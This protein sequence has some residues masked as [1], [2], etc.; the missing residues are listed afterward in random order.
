MTAEASADAARAAADAFARGE[1][2]VLAES[3]ADDAEGNLTIAAQFVTPVAIGLLGSQAHGLIRLCLT[4]ERWA[5]L[6]LQALVDDDERWQPTISITHQSVSRH[7]ASN[8]DRARTILAAVDPSQTAADFHS[9]GYV[10]PLRARP[11]GVL[12]RAGRTEAAVDLARS[13]G[14]IPAAAMS[15]VMNDDGS[16]AHGAELAR[17]AAARD[18]PLVTV[19]DVIALRRHDEKLVERF[20]TARLPTGFGEFSVIGFQ[21]TLHH[22]HHVAMVKGSIDDVGD[23]PVLVRVHAEC[24]YGDIFSSMLCDCRHNLDLALARIEQEGRGVL[25]Y[26]VRSN[27]DQRFVEVHEHD[28]ALSA[29]DEYGIGA[30]ILA[31]LGLRRITLLTDRPRPITGL[32]GFDLEIVGHEP[33]TP[34]A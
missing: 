19:G 16:V 10:F 31:D 8:E 23:E 28:A 29:M 6:G 18:L 3:H 14:C 33:L 2:V 26:L 30:Q 27:R 13:A 4:D 20:A 12:R 7:G 9:G 11:G 5:E 34:A 15:L 1:L 24:P 17:Y 21:E 32:E 25:V 22:Q